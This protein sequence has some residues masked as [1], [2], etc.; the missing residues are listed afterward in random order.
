M[1]R[2]AQLLVAE[3]RTAHSQWQRDERFSNSV[4]SLA[5]AGASWS[6]QHSMVEAVGPAHCTQ[7]SALQ[8]CST[9]SGVKARRELSTSC[10]VLTRQYHWQ[11]VFSSVSEAFA[12]MA[13]QQ[14]NTMQRTFIS[15]THCNHFPQ[16]DESADFQTLLRLGRWQGVFSSVSEAFAA[17]AAQQL[18]TLCSALRPA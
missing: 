12:A 3:V 6:T 8:L 1:Q 13:A 18:D 2:S 4:F 14:L 11:G 16:S 10:Y 9:L 5:S 15:L 7:C 17:M